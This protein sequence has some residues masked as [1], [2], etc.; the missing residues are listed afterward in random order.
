[1]EGIGNIIVNRINESGIDKS[2][3]IIEINEGTDFSNKVTWDNINYIHSIGVKLAIDDFGNKNANFDAL[4]SKKFSILKIDKQFI[5][6]ISDDYSENEDSSKTIFETMIA[7]CKKLGIKSIV[8]G[9][10][11]KKQLDY[12]RSVGCDSIQGFLF[13]KPIPMNEYKSCIKSK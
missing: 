1:M 12:T 7:L 6:N 10:E 13:S 5:D 9:V 8:E 2:K 4:V 3:I 11:S